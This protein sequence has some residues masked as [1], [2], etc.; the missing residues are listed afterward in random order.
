MKININENY[1]I[2]FDGLNY[3]PFSFFKGTGETY[4]IAGRELV[5]K[6]KWIDSKKYFTNLPNAL[7]WITVH[8]LQAEYEEINLSEYIGIY[9]SKM[10][11]LKV[12][13]QGLK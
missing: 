5:S 3:T 2:D 13:C 1:Y 8:S 4:K 11:E 12:A 9:T 6:D 7:H 10:E